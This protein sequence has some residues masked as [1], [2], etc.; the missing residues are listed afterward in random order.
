MKHRGPDDDGLFVD[1]NVGLGFVRLSI[2]DLSKDGH[3][4]MVDDDLVIIFNG[5]IYNYIEIKQELS[6]EFEFKSKTDTEVIL[7][8]YRKWGKKCLDKLNG[9]FAFVIYNKKTKEIFIARDR[10]GV[11]PFYY[12][13]DENVFAFC[14]EIPPILKILKHKPK[15]DK[16]SIYDFLVY[17]RTNHTENTFFDSIKK[18]QH[19]CCIEINN[20]QFSISTW[21][22][23][24]KC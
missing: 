12:Y 3:Q 13:K 22:N 4:P 8:A 17:N 10:F 20:K 5:E 19:G 24:S 23:L 21:Y 18:L 9:M 14:S 16:Q 7:K 11:K 2:L 15:E 6:S 1:G